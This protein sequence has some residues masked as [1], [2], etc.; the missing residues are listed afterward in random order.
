MDPAAVQA[1]A[2][3]VAQAVVQAQNA[4]AAAAAFALT[5]GRANPAAALDYTTRTGQ[6]VFKDA[7]ES[8]PHKFDVESQSINQFCEDLRDRA[9]KAG[10][11]EGAADILTIPDTDGVDRQ[12]ITNYGQLTPQNITDHVQTYIAA[13]D[14][15]SQNAVQMYHCIMS[16][17]TEAGKN[18]VLA[19]ADKYTVNNELVGPLLFKLVVQKAIVDTRAT[20]THLKEQLMSLDAYMTEVNSNVALFNQHVKITVE[21]L[22]ARGHTTDDIMIGLFK[23]Y[24]AASDREF[25]RYIKD[26]KNKYDDDEDITWEQLMTKAL[27]KYTVLKQEGLWNA[28]SPEAE[29]IVALSSEASHWKRTLTLI[30]RGIGIGELPQKMPQLP[31]HEPDI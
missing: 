25:V 4:P 3:A 30:L 17:L 13:Q 16:S 10:W 29:Q 26:Y 20:T 12:L 23:G 15:R 1:I 14:R 22:T 21:G 5:P 27:N 7:T 31:S 9:I 18:K 8:L 2:A 11:G 24:M 19:E 28:L 6:A